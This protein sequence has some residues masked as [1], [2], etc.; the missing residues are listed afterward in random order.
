MD[1]LCTASTGRAEFTS[2]TAVDSRL[3]PV[4]NTI[5]AAGRRTGIAETNPRSTIIGTATGLSIRTWLWTGATTV[6]ITLFAIS[7]GII[8]ALNHTDVVLTNIG[9]AVFGSDAG[10]ACQTTTTAPAAV[11]ITLITLSLI[12][13]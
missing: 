13:I 8:A 10:S 1:V 5:I 2:G 12:H 11:G 3:T 7:H 6:H 9:C 4:Q